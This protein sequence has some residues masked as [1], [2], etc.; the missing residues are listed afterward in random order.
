VVGRVASKVYGTGSVQR[1]QK[2]VGEV[3]LHVKTLEERRWSAVPVDPCEPEIGQNQTLAAAEACEEAAGVKDSKKS[4]APRQSRQVGGSGNRT[5][6]LV[7]PLNGT[8]GEQ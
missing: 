1:E 4:R 5:E 6:G 3:D 8:W 2:R 7:L